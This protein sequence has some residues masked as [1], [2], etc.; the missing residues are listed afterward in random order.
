MPL[1]R[2]QALEI[3][4]T[5]E[6]SIKK[7]LSPDGAFMKGIISEVIKTITSE[8]EARFK[9]LENE[10]QE[11]RTENAKLKDKIQS[12]IDIMEQYSSRNI[13]RIF[14]FVEKDEEDLEGNVI[15][16]FKEKLQSRYTPKI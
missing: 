3:N 8:L 5:V 1:T 10:N 9:K 13:V 12:K 16:L 14:G 2:E 15:Q 11:L 4:N 6:V 7:V